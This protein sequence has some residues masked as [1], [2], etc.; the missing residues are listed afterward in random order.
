LY[1][2]LYR[3]QEGSGFSTVNGHEVSEKIDT[4]SNL[5]N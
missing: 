3:I 5:L 2:E 1:A 4:D